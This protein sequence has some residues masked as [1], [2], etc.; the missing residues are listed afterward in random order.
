MY[1]RGWLLILVQLVGCG[2][3]HQ[4]APPSSSPV[5]HT[6]ELFSDVYGIDTKYKSMRGPSG[7]KSL[8][9]LE[10]D[11]ELLWIVG[12]ETLVVDAERDEPMSQEF[13]CHANLDFDA[14]EYYD[15][16]KSSVPLSGRVFTLSQGQ[17]TIAFP[18]GFGIPVGSHLPL[19]LATQVLN[20]NLDDPDLQVRHHIKIHFV[21]DK[22]VT[23]PMIPLFQGAV[24][25]FKS[26]EDARYYGVPEGEVDP[27]LHGQGC[28][29]G[30]PAAGGSTDDDEFG[31][32][33]TAHWV[34][35]PGREVNVTNVTRFLNLP[36]DTEVHYIA[37]HLHPFAESLTLRDLT[38]NRD[39][40][41]AKVDNSKNRI[42]IDR[43]DYYSSDEGIK[44][45]KDHQYELISVYDNTSGE[46]ADS[47]AVMYL[48]L[49]EK[50]FKKPDFALKLQ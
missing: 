18:Q 14:A 38:L 5:V 24:E 37:V 8:Q 32:R 25:G 4:E 26:L 2:L 6:K 13:M 11:P 21:R 39:I 29:V 36:F 16:F 27:A 48:Y 7:I 33:F 49:H 41:S 34:V 44:L 10:G 45:Y 40:Y 12:Y 1:Q 20:L 42:G 23:T 15:M 47:M 28:S 17:Q 31:Q 50:Q 35:A 30:F 3:R 43:V 9:L 22:E 46:D 19:E